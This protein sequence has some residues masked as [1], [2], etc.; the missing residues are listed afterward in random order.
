[1][2]SAEIAAYERMQEALELDHFGK[3]A[4][5]RDEQL[6]GAYDTFEEA[7]DAAVRNFGRGPYL[8]REIGAGP[9]PLPPS[10]LCRPIYAD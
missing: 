9:I 7:A 5:V 4:V 6:F 8:I 1:M 3:W 2:L 10:L